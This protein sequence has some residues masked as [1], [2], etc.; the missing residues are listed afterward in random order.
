[1]PG[2]AVAQRQP[3]GG[4]GIRPGLH[5]DLAVLVGPPGDGGVDRQEGRVRLREPGAAGPTK[6]VSDTCCR[7]TR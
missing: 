1:M 7:S 3:H 6:G 4:S 2:A 5:D